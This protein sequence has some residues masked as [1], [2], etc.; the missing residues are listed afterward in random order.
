MTYEEVDRAE[1]KAHY[2]LTEALAEEK[3]LHKEY[4]L[5][6]SKTSAARSVWLSMCEKKRELTQQEATK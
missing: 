3:R 6:L 5:A 2:L 1:S 4:A